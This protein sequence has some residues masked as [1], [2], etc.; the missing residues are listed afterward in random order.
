MATGKRYYWMRLKESFMSSDTVDYFMEQPSGANYVVLYQ[1]LC[2]KT[3]NTAG[4]LERRIGDVYIPYDIPKIQRD[5][6]WFSED[7]IRVAL[8]LYKSCGLIYEDKDGV[9]VIADHNK[10]VGSETDYAEQKKIQRGQKH[11]QKQLPT[12]KAEDTEEDK[13]EDSVEDSNGDSIEDNAVDTPEDNDV[14]IAMD[15]GVDIVHTDIRDKEIRD[16]DIRDIENRVYRERGGAISNSPLPEGDSRS[17]TQPHPRKKSE[18]VKPEKEPAVYQI[19]LNDGSM[20]DVTETD[21]NQ[22]RQLYPA[23]DVDQ[24]IRNIVAWN[25]AN[26]KRRKTKTGIKSHITSWLSRSQNRG[27]WGKQTASRQVASNPYA[28]TY[29]D[30]QLP[31]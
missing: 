28:Y 18:K 24:E 2:L 26:P 4:R 6:K 8:G 7:T 3:I 29:E 31:Y 30:D 10:L 17:V 20:H 12:P 9:L 19:P 15:N 14:D 13:T 25:L 23:L 11:D 27:G 16:I 21:L 5:T 22:Y 1:M